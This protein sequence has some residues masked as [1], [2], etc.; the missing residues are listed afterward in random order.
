MTPIATWAR[1]RRTMALKGIEPSSRRCGSQPVSKPN[2][3]CM[4]CPAWISIMIGASSADMMISKRR[5]EDEPIAPPPPR[6]VRALEAGRDAGRRSWAESRIVMV[7]AKRLSDRAAS[8]RG[9][10]GNRV[11]SLVK[12]SGRDVARLQDEHDADEEL[13]HPERR[14]DIGHDAGD[15]MLARGEAQTF[16][17]QARADA[18]D[19]PGTSAG[20]A[21]RGRSARAGSPRSCRRVVGSM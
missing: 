21:P 3:K 14:G 2:T 13:Q 17:R 16:R 1:W 12:Y 4:T 7:R 15:E 5:R 9:Q 10:V 19:C 20:R 6:R 11:K 18:A 8:N